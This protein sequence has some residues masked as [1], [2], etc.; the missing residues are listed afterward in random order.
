MRPSHC[1]ISGLL[2]VA[3]TLSFAG[4]A[5]VFRRTGKSL[6][7]GPNP[8]AVI[9]LDLNGD[10]YPEIVTADRGKLASPQSARPA[11]NELSLL[12]AR[13]FLDYAP[14]RVRG[15]GFGPYAI[16][17]ANIDVY[18]APDILVANFHAADNEDLSLLCNRDGIFD[19]DESNMREL[20]FGFGVPD[21]R[22]QYYRRRTGGAPVFTNPGLTA[23][24]TYD[25][26]GDGL[27]DV[28]AT[29][30]SSDVLVF[31]PGHAETFFGDPVLFPAPGG[32]RDIRRA[33]FDHD[34]IQDLVTVMY[35]SGELVF[36]KGDG[37]GGFTEANRFAC[38]AALP[39]QVRVGDLNRDGHLDV[40][41]THRHSADSV[42]ICYGD[43]GFE[44]RVWQEESLGED[45]SVVEHE[46]RDIVLDDLNGDGKLDLALACAA[47]KRVAV[48]IN[49]A[50]TKARDQA[51]RTEHYTFKEGQPHALTVAEV[52][53]DDYKDLVV[54]LWEI[55]EINFLLGSGG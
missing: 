26:N 24:T 3:C 13:D 6:T 12:V 25:A 11:H 52:N 17:V 42:T 48:L 9:A 41:V 14:R 53:G 55:N 35:N 16:S 43:G 36:W 51:F 31:F 28:I 46:I 37:M 38:R 19:I 39:Q 30:W 22:L 7:V 20:K 32:P 2:V 1:L 5:D 10:E 40:V 4:S 29:G 33:D 54:A 18:P 45:R 50:S 44:F 27:R 34:G 23:L 49:T 47:S 8:C 15:A 21:D